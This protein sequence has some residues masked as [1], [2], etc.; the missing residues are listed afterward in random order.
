MRTRGEE[1]RGSREIDEE[2]GR[3]SRRDEDE[4]RGMERK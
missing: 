4:G 2:E 1:G 3:G